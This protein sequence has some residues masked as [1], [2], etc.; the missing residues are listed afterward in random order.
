MSRR[1]LPSCILIALM[2]GPAPAA[3]PLR[4]IKGWVVDYRE[5]QCLASREYTSAND[6]ITLAV[7]PAP[8]GET[9]ELMVGVKHG[10]PD[11]ATE[12]KG[13]VDFGNGRINSWLLHYG[14]RKT[15]AD[16]YQFR[17]TS[18]EMQ[19]AS[20]A[21][22]VTLTL[23]R[24]LDFTFALSSMPALLAGL[25]TCTDDLK[26]YWN[27]DGEERGLIST[28]S[29]GG[30]RALFSAEDY[31]LE[32]YNRQQEGS[33]QLLLLVDEKGVVAGCHVLT[34]SNIPVIDA[35]GC[36]VINERAKFSPALDRAGK[37]TRST[38]VTPKI[39][40][41]MEGSHNSR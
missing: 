24:G 22:S 34:P 39:V 38:V 9:F 2:M 14:F 31:P 13:Y 18:A 12:E 3:E 37:P 40:W 41:R 7:R 27:M 36:Q 11:F 26:R 21:P 29:K 33:I 25:Q 4:P 8:N 32:A 10:G 28:S 23:D 17:I 15:H 16:V 30:L 1:L 20:K 5:D 19:Q 6:P 35:M